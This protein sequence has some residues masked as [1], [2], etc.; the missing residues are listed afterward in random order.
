MIPSPGISLGDRGVRRPT[1]MAGGGAATES[2][3]V[4]CGI[5]CRSAGRSGAT[6]RGYV[7]DQAAGRPRDTPV[8]PVGNG[9]WRGMDEMDP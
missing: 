5:V 7:L 1:C 9:R 4:T 3:A 2:G 6:R 8:S